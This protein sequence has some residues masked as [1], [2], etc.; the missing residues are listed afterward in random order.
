MSPDC[1]VIYPSTNTKMGKYL[2]V[3]RSFIDGRGVQI[4]LYGY[5]KA[6][7]IPSIVM[8]A[9]ILKDQDEEDNDEEEEQGM[10]ARF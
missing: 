6:R 10:L 3:T 4:V 8:S 2:D 7:S 1:I 5:H 9:S